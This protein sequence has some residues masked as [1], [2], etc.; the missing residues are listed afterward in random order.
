MSVLISCCKE[1]HDKYLSLIDIA[2]AFNSSV[3]CK[4]LICVVTGYLT[5]SLMW[6]F[7]SDPAQ[8]VTRDFAES[9][10]KEENCYLALSFLRSEPTDK[11]QLS[12]DAPC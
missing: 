6:A 12:S 4:V 11:S 3:E 9:F 5:E 7:P 1:K 2:E 8:R 10:I